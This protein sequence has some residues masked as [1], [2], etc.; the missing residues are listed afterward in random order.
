MI[1]HSISL[2]MLDNNGYLDPVAKEGWITVTQDWIRNASIQYIS[3][4]TCTTN[5]PSLYAT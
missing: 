3:D 2:V 4:T 1:L 5:N